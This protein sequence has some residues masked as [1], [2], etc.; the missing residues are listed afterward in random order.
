VCSDDRL[1]V[2]HWGAENWPRLKR[3]LASL[4]GAPT[5]RDMDGVP[6]NCHQLRGDRAGQFAVDLWGSFR[7]VFEPDHEPVPALPDGGV[8]RARVTAIMIK[9]VV[10]YH[11]N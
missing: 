1:G 8:D 9:E 10:D 4:L 6:G 5:L 3:R 11:G 2:R 7:L